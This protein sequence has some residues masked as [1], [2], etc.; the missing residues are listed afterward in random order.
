M[1]FKPPPSRDRIF[2]FQKK[3]KVFTSLLSAFIGCYCAYQ[4]YTEYIHKSAHSF[5]D[6][7][8]DLFGAA[9]FFGVGLFLYTNRANNTQRYDDIRGYGP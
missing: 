5:S 9:L 7:L 2:A 1:K 3:L 6:G 4:A 8:S